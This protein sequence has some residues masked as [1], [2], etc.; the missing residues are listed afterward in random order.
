MRV[1]GFTLVE[2]LVALFITAIMFAMGYA[3]IN[4]GLNEREALRARQDRLS[5][6]QNAM[7]ILAQDFVQVAPRPVREPVG[8][9][10]QP[11]LVGS[12]ESQPLVVFTRAGWANPAG[13][14]RPA[15][16]R[17]AYVLEDGTLRRL[18]WR[19]LDPT[20]SNTPV[21]R[22]LLDRVRSVR[23]RYMDPTRQ[24]RDQWPPQSNVPLGT[25]PAAPGGLDPR[26]RMRPIA[27]EIVLELED[28]GEIVRIIEVAS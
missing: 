1:R 13:I 19:V 23:F 7:R 16:Q 10:M 26:L 12:A 17:V 25:N 11:A 3:A 20:L 2:L 4:Q 21:R 24:W 5:A 8:D 9:G 15:L 6:V 18:H 28:W 14:Q 22:D 27:V